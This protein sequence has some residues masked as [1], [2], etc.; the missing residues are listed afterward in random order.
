MKVPGIA[1]LA[2]AGLVLAGATAEASAPSWAVS[3][4]VVQAG[5]A[6]CKG[7]D[8]CTRNRKCVTSGGECYAWEAGDPADEN[9]NGDDCGCHV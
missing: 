4:E 9:A 8:S 5:A 7:T 2:L 1:A 6:D 3:F